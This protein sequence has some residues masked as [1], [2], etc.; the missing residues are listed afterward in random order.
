[1][2]SYLTNELQGLKKAILLFCSLASI[3]ASGSEGNFCPSCSNF[4]FREN[5]NQWHGDV[6]FEGELRHGKVFLENSGFTYLVYD[7][8]SMQHFADAHHGHAEKL[9][10]EDAVFKAHALKIHFENAL[11]VTPKGENMAGEY[12]NYY[13]GNDKTKWASKVRGFGEVRYKELYPRIDLLTYAQNGNFKY[14]YVVKAGGDVSQIALRYEGA[15][16]MKVRNERLVI[17]TSVGDVVE[18][19]P[20]AYQFVEG[21]KKEVKCRFRLQDQTVQFEFPEGYDREHELTIDPTLIFSTYSGSFADNFG[22]TATY[23]GRGN[24]Y[25]GG[26][27]FHMFAFPTT[28]GAIQQSWAGGVG[29]QIPQFYSGTGTD[30]GITKYDSAGTVRLYS[31]YFGGRY[32][33]LPHSMVVNSN[34]ELILF[35][36][37]GSDNFPVTAN[38]FDT[39]YNGG[40]NPGTFNGI[41]VHYLFGSDIVVARFS[42]DGTVLLGSTYVGGSDNDGLNYPISL[43]L[44]YNYADEIRGEVDLDENDNVIVATCTRSSDFPVTNHTYQ[45][46]YGGGRMDGCVFKLNSSLSQMI[47]GSYLGG[48]QDDAAYSIAFDKN[49]DIYVAGGT[50]SPDFPVTIGA[51][52]GSFNG[53]RCD[54]FISHLTKDGRQLLHSTYYGS[55]AYDQIY[56]VECSKKNEVYVLGQTEIGDST[57]IK[58]SLYNKPGSGQF[59]SKL[60]PQLDSVRFSNVFGSGSGKPDIS[61]TA[62]LVDLCNKIYVSGWGSNLGIAGVSALSTAN[63]DITSNAYQ[64]STDNNDFY[65]MVMEDDASLLN[66]ATYFGSSVSEE[67]VDGGTSRFD[68]KGVVYQSVCAGCGGNSAFPTAPANVVSH[69]N[70][71]PNCNNAIFKFDFNLPVI[72]ADFLAPASGCAPVNAQ[73]VNKSK[74]F[75]TT[76]FQWFFGDGATSTATNPSHTYNNAGL[77]NIMLVVFDP[78]SCNLRDTFERQILILN[79]KRDTLPSA[80]ICAPVPVQLGF[81]P[82]N[83]NSI[84]FQWSPTIYLSDIDISNPIATP[85]ST[86]RY[87]LYAYNGVCRDTF[88]QTITVFRP[89]FHVVQDSVICPGDT[90]RVAVVDEQHLSGVHYSYTLQ[91]FILFGNG[92]PSIGLQPPVD[93]T[94]HISITSDSGCVVNFD[95]PL[96]VR[97]N[98]EVHAAFTLPATGCVPVSGTI[99]NHSTGTG[100][101]TTYL[102]RFGDGGTATGFNAT[103]TWTTADTF[104]ITLIVSDVTKLCHSVDSLTLPFLTIQ[105]NQTVLLPDDTFCKGLTRQIGLINGIDTTATLSWSP[106]AH[107]SN[108]SIK[109]PFATPDTSTTYTL[110]VSKNG[111]NAIYKQRLVLVEDSFYLKGDTAACPY[112]TI[113]L[114]YEHRATATSY[115]YHWQPKGLFIEGDTTATPLMR[116]NRDTIITVQ[117]ENRFGCVF[118]DTFAI[119][120]TTEKIISAAFAGP[121]NGCLPFTASFL[122]NSHGLPTTTYLWDFGDNTSSNL[123]QPTHNYISGG[124]YQV[125]LTLT[126]SN[127]CNRKDTATLPILLLDQHR[128]TLP[129]KHLCLGQSVVLGVSS[130]NDPN[131]HFS[132]TPVTSLNNPFIANPTASPVTSTNYMLLVNNNAC[133]DTFMQRVLL[134]HQSFSFVQDTVPCPADSF[135]VRLINASGFPISVNWQPLS[136]LLRQSDS[137]A[138]IQTPEDTFLRV[139][140]TNALGCVA[141]DSFRVQVLDELSVKALFRAPL[142]GCAPFT[143]NFVNAS[144]AVGTPVYHWNF[145]DQNTSTQTNPQ[146]IYSDTGTYVV[147]LVVSDPTA[148]CSTIDSFKQTITVAQN[149][150]HFLLPVDTICYGSGALIGPQSGSDTSSIFRWHPNYELSDTTVAHPFASPKMDTTYF[151]EVSTSNCRFSYEQHLLVLHDSIHITGTDPNCSKSAVTLN[152]HYSRTDETLNYQWSPSAYILNGQGF[153]QVVVQPPV[154]TLFSV[155]ATNAFGCELRDTVAVNIFNSLSGNIN[156]TATPS[157]IHYGDSSQL[158]A[159]ANVPATLHWRFE[160]TLSDSLSNHPKAFPSKTTVYIVEFTDENSCKKEDT[161]IVTVERNPCAASLFVPNAFSPNGDGKNDVFRVRGNDIVSIYLAVYDRW[162][163]LMFETKSLNDVWDGTFKGAKLDPAVFGWYAEVNCLNSKGSEIKKGNVTLLR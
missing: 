110:T 68:R 15:T 163:Q 130:F 10:K 141:N 111:C 113:R 80:Y 19:A 102:W 66:Y 105:N 135:H 13:L 11:T 7:S 143:A 86:I 124:W 3:W 150:Q 123:F 5:K 128:D 134:F 39:T 70:N 29:Y 144:H 58:N 63:L 14:D 145:G 40:T 139:T 52:E 125:R 64:P 33:D 112:D 25:A 12:F 162:G 57:F 24:A 75:P 89:G 92:T 26:S 74:T 76:T 4:L 161:V 59:I 50:L 91:P 78:S 93:T 119:H 83:D 61:P 62:F 142:L 158:Q 17:G 121:G 140:I 88:Q 129:D 1:M 47:W 81:P 149:F 73:F 133:N 115:Q 85:D 82:L 87:Y 90:L 35:G 72:V 146:H 34:N 56:F 131:L 100:P 156:A 65:L 117:A 37:T 152:A 28:P 157:T 69:T 97:L 79:S 43:V 122:N 138:T 42:E 96:K 107:L 36:T 160:P 6:R 147:T 114:H 95:A 48:S 20:Y 153:D 22:Y 126:D 38:A 54:G 103:H 94:L 155:S 44:N 127:S 109:S 104:R 45:G 137:T 77:F 2:F 8:A 46:T 101:S 55:P 21:S 71:S 108:P 84:Q 67:H 99:Q 16:K 41:A 51:Y 120:A 132:W 159:T 136:L 106:A 32:D 18:L 116:V 154:N 148:P 53:G 118:Y 49:K 23:D 9:S 30:M 98:N 31:T 60:S 151:L 27:V